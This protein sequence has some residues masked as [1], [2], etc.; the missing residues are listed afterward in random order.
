MILYRNTIAVIGSRRYKNQSMVND[1]LNKK[2]GDTDRN[3]ILLLSGGCEGPD[4]W[5]KMWSINHNIPFIEVIPGGTTG[6][7]YFE[8]NSIMSELADSIIAFIPRGQMQSGTWNTILYFR[9]KDTDNYE[10]YDENG[11]RWDRDWKSRNWTTV[12][13]PGFFGS[14]RNELYMKWDE[15]YK[16]HHWRLAYVWGESIISRQMALCLY[17]DAYYV[18]LR[19]NP[20]VL[21]NLI[22]S[23]SDVYDNAESNIYSGTDYTIQ[24]QKSTH[25]QDIAIRRVLR[26]MGK[27]FQGDKLLQIRSN[28]DEGKILSPKNVPF[29]IPNMIHDGK[30]KDYGKKGKWWNDGS[31]E[32][33]YQRNKVLQI[34]T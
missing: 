28:S 14:M 2:L 17:E 29:H 27:W 21:K 16:P 18:F 4:I 12:E 7:Y 6:K 30:I 5:G 15:M 25:L 19:D 33:F 3:E 22:N 20:D 23:A 13:H 11:N 1:I 10:V 31:I 8:R 9:T 32:D 24:E 26:R 34:F